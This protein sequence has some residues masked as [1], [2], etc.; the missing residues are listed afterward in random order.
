MPKVY[1]CSL[2]PSIFYFGPPL[3]ARLSW[4]EWKYKKCNV[5]RWTFVTGYL[6]AFRKVWYIYLE[7]PIYISSHFFFLGTLYAAPSGLKKF[8][9]M[10]R[11]CNA[12]RWT[13]VAST[14]FGSGRII[15]RTGS[16]IGSQI[17]S[18]MEKKIVLINK[19]KSNHLQ[20][21]DT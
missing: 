18:W 19:K 6:R 21:N 7:I 11:K 8:G 14:K 5:N 9:L 13:A 17:R 15:S 2:I 20:D 1:P 16:R 4:K 12:N 3:A 10:W